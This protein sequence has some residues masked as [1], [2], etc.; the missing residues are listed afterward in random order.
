MKRFAKGEYF[1]F[2]TVGDVDRINEQFR[3]A[4]DVALLCQFEAF[5]RGLVGDIFVQ[6]LDDNPDW[7]FHKTFFVS[8]ASRH[9]DYK[10]ERKPRGLN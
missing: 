8:A 1:G 4:L 9:F 5:D 3:D 2:E 7:T 6:V 10:H